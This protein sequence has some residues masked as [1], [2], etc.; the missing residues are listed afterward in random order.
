MI[1]IAII[2]ISRLPADWLVYLLATMPAQQPENLVGFLWAAIGTM[3]TVIV[4]LAAYI[5]YL[6]SYIF[7]S[8]KERRVQD[9]AMAEKRITADM[10]T[11]ETIKDVT[12]ALVMLGEKL[13]RQSRARR[14][15]GKTG[16][17]S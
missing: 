9:V 16:K 12:E 11:R 3:G 8:E 14:N 5:R 13:E 1:L 10:E 2:F 4:A 6:L 15:N 7:A 17:T